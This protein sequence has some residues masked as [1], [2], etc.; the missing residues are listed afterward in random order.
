MAAVQMESTMWHTVEGVP[1]DVGQT[2]AIDDEL[3][4]VGEVSLLE[5]LEAL[6]FA[7]RAPEV[8]P[9]PPAPPA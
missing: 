8:E 9:P 2:Y 7:K 3:H 6:H 1:Y 5:T 4:K